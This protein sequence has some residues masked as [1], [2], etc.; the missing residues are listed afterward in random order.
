MVDHSLA[1]GP[2]LVTVACVGFQESACIL[3]AAEWLLQF[4]LSIWSMLKTLL[5][6]G[7]GLCNCSTS[8]DVSQHLIPTGE[9]T[10]LLGLSQMPSSAMNPAGFVSW[11]QGWHQPSTQLAQKPAQ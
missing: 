10:A 9:N 11:Q 3:D 6:T 7:Q 4:S 2:R 8:A 1:I 5:E